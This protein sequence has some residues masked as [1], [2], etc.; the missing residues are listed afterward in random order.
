MC[1]AWCRQR[2]FVERVATTDQESREWPNDAIM[3]SNISRGV[4]SVRY[5]ATGDWNRRCS[6]GDSFGQAMAVAHEMALWTSQAFRLALVLRQNP[7]RRSLRGR[8][9][10][11]LPGNRPARSRRLRC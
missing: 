2:C 5:E 10:H 6:G 11:R 7:D 4:S 1:E 9:D 3:A 8:E